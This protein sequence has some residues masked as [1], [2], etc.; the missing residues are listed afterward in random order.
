MGVLPAS[1]KTEK[2]MNTCRNYRFRQRNLFAFF[3]LVFCVLHHVLLA[4]LPPAKVQLK[5]VAAGNHLS[6]IDGGSDGTTSTVKYE[7]G[8]GVVKGSYSVIGESSGLS[9]LDETAVPGQTCYYAIREGYTGWLPAPVQTFKIEAKD[10]YTNSW[11]G[12]QIKVFDSSDVQIG[13]ITVPS[14]TTTALVRIDDQPAGAYSF[15][16]YPGTLDNECSFTIYDANDNAIYT[17][18]DAS[19]F[20]KLSFR[21]EVADSGSNGWNGAYIGVV[22]SSNTEIKQVTCSGSTGSVLLKNLPV[23]TYSFVWHPGTADNE[24]SFTIYDSVDTVINTCSDA[25]VYTRLS[26]RIEAADSGSNGWNGAYIGILNSSNTE[27]KQVTCSGSSSSVMVNNLAAGTYSFVWHP[28]TSDNECSFTVYNAA[29][30]AISSCADALAAYG[31]GFRVVATDTAGN[32]WDGAYISIRNSSNVEVGQA[33]CAGA[34]NVATVTGLPAGTYTFVWNPGGVDS[35]CG[36]SICNLDGSVIYTC[37]NASTLSATV[38]KILHRDTFGDGWNGAYIGIHNDLDVEVAQAIMTSGS[39]KTSTISLPAGAYSFYW[40]PGSWDSECNFDIYYQGGVYTCTNARTTFNLTVTQFLTGVSPYIEFSFLSV[41]KALNKFLSGVSVASPLTTFAS[42]NVSTSPQTEFLSDVN[43]IINPPEDTTGTRFTDWTNPVM[44][45]F[46]LQGLTDDA[47]VYTNESVV[48]ARWPSYDGECVKTFVGL[49]DTPGEDNILS[50]VD[51]GHAT[52]HVFQN[53][54]LQES[55]NY[56]ITVKIQDSDS[57]SAGYGTSICSSKG[58]SFSSVRDLIDTAD[59]RYFNN[60]LVKQLVQITPSSVKTLPFA[61]NVLRPCRVPVKVI[62]PGI[63]SRVNAPV[64]FILTGSGLNDPV[65]AGNQIRVADESGN[66][67]PCS[68]VAA[69]TAGVTMVMIVNVPTGGSKNYWVSW[70]AGSTSPTA[71]PTNTYATSQTAWT[72]YYSRKLLPPGPEIW[73]LESYTK[74]DEPDNSDDDS[75]YVTLPWPFPYFNKSFPGIYFNTNSCLTPDYFWQ[76]YNEFTTFAGN[77]FPYGMIAMIWCDTMA[78]RWGGTPYQPVPQNSGM[79]TLL[80]DAGLPT[81]RMI[82]YFRGN[83][84]N[85]LDDIYIH[86][87]ILYKSGDIAIRYEYLS[88]GA[89]WEDGMGT[90]EGV[91]DREN[92]VGISNQDGINYFV[93]TPLIAGIGKTPTSFFQYKNAM[94]AIQGPIE[95]AGE[96]GGINYSFAGH[97]ESAVFDS[98]MASPQWQNVKADFTPNG[99]RFTFQ[100]RSGTTPFPDSSWGEWISVGAASTSSDIDFTFSSSDPTFRKRYMQYRCIFLKEQP[101]DDPTLEEVQFACRG[102]EITGITADTPEGVTQGQQNIRVTV[103]VKNSYPAQT[104]TVNSLNLIYSLGS[105]TTLLDSPV[106]PTS[107]APGASKEFVFLVSVKSDSPVGTATIDANVSSLIDGLDFSDDGADRKHTWLI[108]SA[109][110]IDIESVS[111]IPLTVNKGQTVKVGLRFR[112]KGGTPYI[113]DS[114]ELNFSLGNYTQILESPALGTIVEP[115]QTV[116]GTFSVKVEENSPSGIAII[117]ASIEGRNKLSDLLVGA[118]GAAFNDSWTVQNPAKLVF[119]AIIASGTVYR[120]Q[121]NVPV[122]LKVTN[123]GEALAWWDASSLT[124]SSGSYD[125]IVSESEFPIGI[126]GGL[127]QTARYLVN[128]SVDS[129]TGPVQITVAGYG[130]DGNTNSDLEISPPAAPA[131]WTIIAERVKT[132]KDTGMQLESASFNRPAVGKT[133]EVFAKSSGLTPLKEY[134]VRWYRPDGTEF[135]KTTTP[136]T[137]DLSGSISH[138]ITLQPTDPFGIWTVKITNPLNTRLFCQN[139]FSLVDFAV[140]GVSITLPEKVSVGQMFTSH[141]LAENTGGAVLSNSYPGTLV[142]GG[143][144]NVA[145]ISGPI[146][147]MQNVAPGAVATFTWQWQA[148]TA[149]T[150]TIEGTLYGYDANSDQLLAAATATSNICTVQTAPVLSV[151]AI[152]E[153]YNQ[154]FL[155]QKNL[156]VV[157]RINNAGEADAVVEGASLTFDAGAQSQLIDPPI[158]FPFTVAGGAFSDIRFL[159]SIAENSLTGL[160]NIGGSFSAYDRNNPSV[161]YAL[162]GGSASWTISRVK[163]LCSAN[164][165]YNPEQYSFNKNQTVYARFTDLPLNTSYRIRFYNVQSGGSPVK[166]SPPLNSG[167]YG[168]CDDLWT[169]DSTLDA[170]LT[171]GWRVIIDQGGSAGTTGTLV[172]QQFFQVMEPGNLVAT[173]TLSPSSVFIGET[174]T[175]TLET[176]NTVADGSTIEAV[177]AA[178]LARNSGSVGNVRLLSGP[179]P[180]KTEVTP[181]TPGIFTWT[182]EAVEDTGFSGN[183]SMA[184]VLS[185]SATG[186]DKNTLQ[187]VFSNLSVSNDICIF[188]RGL[189][190]GSATLDFGTVLPGSKSLSQF[191][192]IL[193]TGNYRLDNV[194]ISGVD[195]CNETFDYISNANVSFL[196]DPIGMIDIS[197]QIVVEGA[198][199]I[200]YFQQPG[201]YRAK[202]NVFE[203]VNGNSNRDF[204]EPYGLFDAIAVVPVCKLISIENPVIEMGC[205]DYGQTSRELFLEFLSGGNGPLG[206]LKLTQ[207]GVSAD[208]FTINFPKENSGLAVG[209]K[210]SLGIV[211]APHAGIPYG[212]Y[213]I[214]FAIYDDDDDDDILDATET[215][216]EFS[217]K[218]AVGKKLFTLDPANVSFAGAAPASVIEG[219]AFSVKNDGVYALTYLTAAPGDLIH[220][221][222]TDVIQGENLAAFLPASVDGG[223]QQPAEVSVYIPAGTPVGTY[224]G[225]LTVFEDTDGNSI[226]ESL[227][228]KR[229]LV[230]TISVKAQAGVQVVESFVDVGDATANSSITKSFLCRNIG[231]V[232][233]TRLNFEKVDLLSET[234]SISRDAVSFGTEPDTV[235]PGQMFYRDATIN[236]P[237]AQPNGLYIGRLAW[238]FEDNYTQDGLRE[239]EEPQSAF[240]LSCQVGEIVVDVLETSA[241]TSGNPNAISA[242]GNFSIYNAGSLRLVNPVATAS[243]LIFGANVIPASQSLFVPST[244]GYIVPGQTKAITWQVSIPANTPAGVYTG[245]LTVWND[246][247]RDGMIG[248]GEVSD[249]ATLELSVNSKRDV[250]IIQ[251]PRLDIGLSAANITAKKTFQIFNSGNLPLTDLK[252]LKEPL[253]QSGVDIIP[254]ES[255]T[256]EIPSGSLAP[257]NWLLATVSVD[258]GSQLT[259][260]Y[261]GNF[262]VYTDYL[263]PVGYTTEESV[264]CGLRLGIV[265]KD[266]QIS[267]PVDFPDAFPYQQDV[268]SAEKT[269]TNSTEFPLSR[270]K[271]KV[272][273]LVSDSGG[274]IASAGFVFS[275]PAPASLE[276]GIGKSLNYHGVAEILPLAPATLVVPGNYIGTHTVWEDDDNDDIP[277]L[278]RETCKTFVSRIKVKDYPALEI[279]SASADLGEV[280]QGSSSFKIPV[281]I[282]NVGNCQLN[283]TNCP[284]ASSWFPTSLFNGALTITSENLYIDPLPTLEMGQT[285]TVNVWVTVPVAT[286]IG[287]YESNPA[288]PSRLSGVGGGDS[289][290]FKV[291][292]LLGDTTPP[293]G[294]IVTTEGPF[295]SS[296]TQLSA[297][298]TESHDLESGVRGYDFAIGTTPGGVDI[299]GYTNVFTTLS[300]TQTGISPAIAD[301]VTCYISVRIWNNNDLFT[302]STSDCIRV[303][304]TPPAIPAMKPE[305]AYASGTVNIVSCDAVTD[306]VSGGVTYSFDCSTDPAFGSVLSS[307]AWLSEPSYE[308]T[309]LNDGV[310]Y[311]FRV[312]ARDAVL[313]ES[314]FSSG[315]SSTQDSLPPSATGY[316]DNVADNNDPDYVWSRDASV[317]FAA[318]GLTDNLSGV[319]DVYVEIANENTFTPPVLFSGWVGNTS[320]SKTFVVPSAA[321]GEK[322]FARAQFEDIAGNR[323]SAWLNSDGITLDLADPIA[324]AT[325][326]NVADNDD[327]DYL[328]SSDSWIYFSFTHSDTVSGVKDVH[329]QI[330]KDTGFTQI[331][332]STLLGSPV[333]SYAY[334]YGEDG[335][336][337]YA[338]I[339]V[340]D[341][342]G[343]YSDGTLTFAAA[344]VFG[345]RSDGIRVDLTPPSPAVAAFYINKKDGEFVGESTTATSVVRLTFTVS[346]PSGISKAAISN[347]GSTWVSFLNPALDPASHPW[348]LDLTP[349]PKTVHAIFTD[350]LGHAS[351]VMQQNIEYWPVYK[352]FIGT[353]ADQNY[354]TDTYD[355]YYGQ[356]KYGADRKD[357]S[358]PQQGTSLRLVKP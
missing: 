149:G 170:T 6:W 105:Y 168:V 98:R 262:T 312:R 324:G 135:A 187:P 348:T 191:F 152:T 209:E 228:E 140:P 354:P 104:A 118:T 157:M 229:D 225:H 32:G 280:K 308:F 227:E 155:N 224:E 340:L 11:N 19:V 34:S 176:A 185:S 180:E 337:Y 49:A 66:E 353:R 234:F 122:T 137:A 194:K 142:P 205:L 199:K 22:N 126:Y 24:C 264:G 46:P 276:G 164:P 181:F 344:T 351:A 2:R 281:D 124:F 48:G 114:A 321:D 110:A 88:P 42:A 251:R 235:P 268:L 270:L 303:D 338:R 86:Q 216:G 45:F 129:A 327:P 212:E 107:I 136:L 8:R 316:T 67:V 184:S 286:P 190:V 357:A 103:A 259:G 256:F 319:K 206:N 163:G 231:N 179:S 198:L 85:R 247:D 123:Q 15:V 341:N 222:G 204:D 278:A 145:L 132:Y 43:A 269:I 60:A 352:A 50:F 84:F 69:D 25:S 94:Q 56:Y 221:N 311:Y 246:V 296:N 127:S 139:F 292:V 115:G 267:S 248:A 133:V 95:T 130:R 273:N 7:I 162:T 304:T 183:F 37:S 4:Q 72:N 230:V 201:T 342:S 55:R 322:I 213:T 156:I 12:A 58:F 108:K 258:V 218:I 26:F 23:D 116:A 252:A 90:D 193:N 112:N 242:A 272:G 326:D 154:V 79:Y 64:E 75:I 336:T 358:A 293:E 203:D 93:T 330:A 196:P 275:P 253:L 298:W 238:I 279:L 274:T 244:I 41:T 70:G 210:A 289:L 87:G 325:T 182:Y 192:S 172:A 188:R 111:T 14:A 250:T 350:G 309:G 47:L 5:T 288:D 109:A 165:N 54:S 223:A 237:A 339:R 141:Y 138:Y 257:G 295:T 21:F 211:A 128:I 347:N 345:N 233:L 315:V 161:R 284:I 131:S 31:I 77:S 261:L 314:D 254:A 63:E 232:E 197:S 76:Y 300:H 68:V 202:V 1:A 150:F 27:V 323:T 299:L 52:D 318:V 36:F 302:V 119:S 178:G 317:S 29:G 146:P 35:E 349:G 290:I 171:G 331:A 97:F 44:R 328:V 200:P 241:D 174:I 277:N 282:K 239:P 226:C 153:S 243:E 96:V 240:N 175:A 71:F 28:G 236:I 61:D 195:L 186:K 92:T 18:P 53:A 143:T 144:G 89:L 346:D 255:V 62:E 80:A 297:S 217:V 305:P 220:T 169:L 148:S 17:C 59:I 166:V 263:A 83:R 3:F 260:N 74:L 189:G 313:N 285:G 57:F 287:V 40:H 91:N 355:E 30:T 151:A 356:N 78:Y 10:L 125:S 266:F 249:N 173:L 106:L 51:V 100:V 16:W 33:T 82:F 310:T 320:G 332:T 343:R 265:K 329:I 301:G 219:L 214:N 147:V 9:F 306:A 283:S 294:V 177:I 208:Y 73:P 102:I 38:F 120:G 65:I 159:V 101:V 99:G 215:K 81:E 134:S 113:L 20:S 307:S 335:Q 167:A 39:S 158:T 271:W 245:L 117:D 13:Q 334:A 333:T 160:V 207:T 291:T 121:S